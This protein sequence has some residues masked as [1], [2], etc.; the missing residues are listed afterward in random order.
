MLE[1]RLGFEQ[2]EDGLRM[3]QRDD[4]TTEQNDQNE[5]IQEMR[6]YL[7]N[8]QAYIFSPLEEA[9]HYDE[10]DDDGRA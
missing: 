3:K 10:E 5:W 2:M 8:M 4:G 7:Y 6:E 1:I 9:D